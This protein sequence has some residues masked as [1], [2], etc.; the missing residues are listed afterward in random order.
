MSDFQRRNTRL[1]NRKTRCCTWPETALMELSTGFLGPD[2]LGPSWLQGYSPGRFTDEKD[3]LA[4][5]IHF[6]MS[7]PFPDGPRPPADGWCPVPE[8]E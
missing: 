1:Q 7:D 5:G 6:D 2:P 4:T 3:S 8:R